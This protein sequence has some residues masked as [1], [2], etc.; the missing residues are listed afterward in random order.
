[1]NPG[2]WRHISDTYAEFGMMPAGFSLE[3][4]LYDPNPRVDYTWVY[5]SLGLTA[6]V[7][8][9]ALG[10]VLP[11][12]QLN[13]R[14][15]RS[16]QQYRELVEQAPFP[17]S[18]SDA[19]TQRVVFANRAAA[20]M[21]TVPVAAIEGG[22]AVG[23]YA[24]AADRERLLADL[25]AGRPVTDSEVR[26]RAP[27]GPSRWVLLSAAQVEFAGRRGILV[28]FQDITQRREMQDELQRAKEAAEAA[29]A[30]KSHFLAV[31]T[32]EVRTPLSGIIGLAQLIQHEPLTAE[33]RESMGL[34]ETTGQSLIALIGNILDYSKIE[35]GR[36]ELEHS[37][38]E[39]EPLLKD[40]CRLFSAVAQT[41]NL[42]LAIRIEPGAPAVVFTDSARL[43]Q[44]LGNL[45]S[46]AIKFTAAG[47]ETW[48]GGGTAA[49]WWLANENSGARHRSRYWARKIGAAVSTLHSGGQLRRPPSR[50]HGVGSRNFT[51]AGTASWRRPVGRKHLGSWLNL[52][53]GDR[54]RGDGGGG[55]I[56]RGATRLL[57]LVRL[58]RSQRRSVKISTPAARVSGVRAA[59]R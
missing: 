42:S 37:P 48:R 23:F 32:H 21:M 44:V 3:G 57:P 46:N 34:I 12:V 5:W 7:A 26:L 55:L 54:G 29:N 9:V 15:A 43:R 40:L 20:A 50:R 38:M 45:L 1:M 6:A 27:G 8:L 35:A 56:G 16:E 22:K 17:V 14:L 41:K 39:I 58:A 13:R 53:F 18:V 52:H 51:P 31:M 19:E 33:Q 2:R 4:F 28:A 25:R 24:D 59:S 47:G 49:G 36:M 11:L 10:W 30:A